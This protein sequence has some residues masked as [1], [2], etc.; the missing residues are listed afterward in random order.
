MCLSADLPHQSYNVVGIKMWFHPRQELLMLILM[1]GAL[2]QL[3]LVWHCSHFPLIRHLTQGRFSSP[4]S[5]Y[6]SELDTGRKTLHS[7]LYLLSPAWT[8]PSVTQI[9][10]RRNYGRRCF[11]YYKRLHVFCICVHRGNDFRFFAIIFRGNE[12]RNKHS[13]FAS[14]IRLCTF[15]PTEVFMPTLSLYV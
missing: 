14:E 3:G 6:C 2:W 12:F 1:M 13:K 15:N 7:G 9:T 5:E 11:L 8:N 10:F 4:L